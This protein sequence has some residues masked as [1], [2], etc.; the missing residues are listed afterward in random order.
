[1]EKWINPTEVCPTVSPYRSGLEGPSSLFIS[2]KQIICYQSWHL[3]IKMKKGKYRRAII[4][5]YCA[6]G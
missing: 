4:R 5:E 2:I 1:M 3:S 6:K